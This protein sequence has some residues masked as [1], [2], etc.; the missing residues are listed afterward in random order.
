MSLAFRGVR[1]L[2]GRLEWTQGDFNDDAGLG[3]GSGFG[4]DA[5][6]ASGR[7]I[8][9]NYDNYTKVSMPP[10]RGHLTAMDP[11]VIPISALRVHF[12]AG[13]IVFDFCRESPIVQE[14][15][16]GL[17]SL[18]EYGPYVAKVRCRY[19]RLW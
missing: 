16:F 17:G 18:S 15:R 7:H 4:N 14:P 5:G 13:F 12:E 11:K 19:R 1:F 2:C 9:S 8:R 3:S 6:L 10:R